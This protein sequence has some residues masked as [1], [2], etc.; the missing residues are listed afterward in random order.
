MFGVHDKHIYYSNL[1][2]VVIWFL[3]GCL[4]FYSWLEYNTTE[5]D[6]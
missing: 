2:D 3:Y 1:F 6:C 4:M 5:W